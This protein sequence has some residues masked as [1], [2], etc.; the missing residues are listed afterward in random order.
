MVIYTL[1]PEITSGAAQPLDEQERL[2]LRER[3]YAK[4]KKLVHTAEEISVSAQ[5]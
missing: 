4:F 2:A 1:K 3:I 5:E